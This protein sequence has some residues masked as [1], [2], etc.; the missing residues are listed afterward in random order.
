VK[1]KNRGASS[2]TLNDLN[3]KQK[4]AVY[5]HQGPLLIIAGAGSG[6]TRTITHKIGHLIDQLGVSPENILAVT[7]TNKAAEE[8]RDRVALLTGNT[9]TTPLISTFH[10][11]AARLLRR[12]AQLIGYENDFAICDSLDQR[13]VYRSVY[14]ELGVASEGLSIRMAQSIV[15]RAKNSGRS[16]ENLPYGDLNSSNQSSL[17]E[18]YK[19]YQKHLKRANAMDFDDLILNGVKLLENP[20]ISKQY[21]ALFRYVLVDEYQDTNT[22]QHDLL[23]SL[24]RHHNNVT[25]VG[26]EDQSIYA[27]RG[28]NVANILRFEQ[29]FPGARIIH[30]EQNYRSS[31]IILDAA[32][33]LI[34]NNTR[35]REK[36]LWTEHPEGPPISLFV[37]GDANTEALYVSYKIYSYLREN[38]NKTVGVLYRTNFQSRHFEEEFRRLNIP[39]KMVGGES[40]YNRKEVKDALAYLRVVNN[41]HDTVA[42][43]RII[44]E[45]PRRIGK[46]TVA[47]LEKF[48]R[49][50]N[51]S[52]WGAINQSLE[53]GRLPKASFRALTAFRDL[54][55][56]SQSALQEPLHL[57]LSA[58]LDTVGYRTH[59]QALESDEAKGRLLNLDELITVARES[60]QRNDDIRSFLDNAALYSETDQFDASA[61]VTMMTLHNAKGLEFEVVFL[62]GCEEGLFP[63]NRSSTDEELEEERRLCYVGITR[64][65]KKL[66]FSYSQSRRQYGQGSSSFNLPSRFLNEIPQKC[67]LMES[68]AG[69]GRAHSSSSA[70]YTPTTSKQGTTFA[71]PTYNSKA[72]VQGFLNELGNTKKSPKHRLASGAL[73][74]HR[75]FGRGKVLQVEDLGDDLKVTVRFP[76]IGIKKMFQR[77]A[78]LKIV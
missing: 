14:Q 5:H 8:M 18:I 68:A 77:F 4:E 34:S 36:T 10:S 74:Q 40:F 16:L 29:D 37:A 13:R 22:P 64:A 57:C 73:V 15:S 24:T 63:H 7:F 12:H 69:F 35:R 72:E 23:T 61:P 11:L 2:P 50:Q 45:P 25:A 48:A 26:D 65:R 56:D 55:H 59:L 43:L 39:Y 3:D 28:A 44:N 27:F 47:R 75:K 42:L 62:V 53:T 20:K 17:L 6:K 52:F 30:L 67:L 21:G 58:I 71:G 54:I 31:Q 19:T 38:K 76:G 60:Y 41:P 9:T 49:D 46:T 66:Y 78:H 1:R 51:L 32:S 33:A 70:T